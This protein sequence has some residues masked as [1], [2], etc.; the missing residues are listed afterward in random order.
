M[1]D[2]KEDEFKNLMSPVID[3]A[4]LTNE[5]DKKVLKECLVELTK[6]G[7]SAYVPPIEQNRPGGS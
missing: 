4:L 2:V 1:W 6:Q 7:K 5:N 3:V